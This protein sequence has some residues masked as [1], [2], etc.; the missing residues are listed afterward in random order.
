MSLNKEYIKKYINDERFV[1]GMKWGRVPISHDIL[2][3]EYW[4]YNQV[5][6]LEGTHDKIKYVF[7]KFSC[8]PSVDEEKRLE[9]KT[10]DLLNNIKY[11]SNYSY[12]ATVQDLYYAFLHKK[13]EY[14]MLKLFSVRYGNDLAKKVVSNVLV[15]GDKVVYKER[16]Y[17]FQPNVLY[18]YL[19][20]NVED[21]GDRAKCV[22]TPRK[23]SVTKLLE[24]NPDDP[25]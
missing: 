6:T 5:I 12:E 1:L 14:D 24:V 19:Y 21:V 8:L 17:F 4:I 25:I 3:N 23:T 15:R 10:V 2:R 13:L 9:W 16:I 11:S 20:E 18:C 22:G 7:F